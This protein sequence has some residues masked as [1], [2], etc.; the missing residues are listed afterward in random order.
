M[1]RPAM[2]AMVAVALLL[3]GCVPGY[4]K[5]NDSPVLFLIA[6]INGGTTLTSDVSSQT[7]ETVSLSIAVRAKNP[8]GPTSATIPMHVRLDQYTVRF[9]RTD[10]RDVEGQDVPYHFSGAITGAIDVA[11]SGVSTFQI[12]LV[13]SQAK[14]EPPL[15]NLRAVTGTNPL[16]GA[17]VT[18][19][20]TMIAEITVYGHT[21]ANEKL[22]DTGRVTVDF[23]GGTFVAP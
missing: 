12:P 2:M 7:A 14:Q 19:V 4:V 21:L 16:P 3:P 20:V 1:K 9:F 17:T 6:D 15:R 22:S 23:V 18:P 5:N 11:T 8:K 13:R 10:G